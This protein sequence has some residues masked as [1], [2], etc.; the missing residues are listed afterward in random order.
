MKWEKK[1]SSNQSALTW[2]NKTRLFVQENNSFCKAE[3]SPLF[4]A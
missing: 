4:T 1:S 3:D 2:L